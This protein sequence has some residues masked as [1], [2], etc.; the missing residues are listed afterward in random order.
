MTLQK[1]IYGLNVA[2]KINV[3]EFHT[4]KIF[5]TTRNTISVTRINNIQTMYNS[6]LGSCLDNPFNP[7]LTQE[8]AHQVDG[9]KPLSSLAKEL[10]QSQEFY[11]E[12]VLVSSESPSGNPLA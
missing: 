7:L 11:D 3:V 12:K 1:N 8:L 6:I 2:A 4:L 5:Q 10:I 9:S